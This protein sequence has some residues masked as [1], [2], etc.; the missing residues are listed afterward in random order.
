MASTDNIDL[1]KHPRSVMPLGSFSMKLV[2]SIKGTNYTGKVWDLSRQGC[3]CILKTCDFPDV[4]VLIS[5]IHNQESLLLTLV[6]YLGSREKITAFIKHIDSFSNDSYI[7]G[8]EYEELLPN[9]F[10]GYTIG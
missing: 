10:R 1:R 8:F 9:N 4:S 3:S 7:L 5:M 2:I 6:D